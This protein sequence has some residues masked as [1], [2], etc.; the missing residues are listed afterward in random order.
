LIHCRTVASATSN[1]SA[2]PCTVWYWSCGMASF[3]ALMLKDTDLSSC[4]IDLDQRWARHHRAGWCN[5]SLRC[6]DV[7]AASRWLA[8]AI[9]R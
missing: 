3:P 8:N 4:L 6:A 5:Q 7:F 9:S 2:T 1:L